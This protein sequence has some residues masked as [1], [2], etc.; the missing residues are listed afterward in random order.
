MTNWDKIWKDKKYPMWVSNGGLAGYWDKIAAERFHRLSKNKKSSEKQVEELNLK[1][2]DIVLDIGCGTGRLTLP[3]A[4]R[5]K[6]VYGIDISKEMLEIV[7]RES[8]KEGLKNVKLINADFETFDISNIKKVDVSISYNSLG[9]Y[10][11][12][13][14]LKR[15]DDV[16]K[17]EV[18]IFTFASKGEWLDEHLAE[19]IYGK[20]IKN[21]PTS[22][23]IICNL[24]KERGIIAD[25]EIRHTV[26]KSKYNSVDEAI[27]K[28]ME[29]YKF[30]S[31]LKGEVKNFVRNNYRYDGA[32]YIISQKRDIAKIH[33]RVRNG[34]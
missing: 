2:T 7:K 17:R 29:F 27:E 15:I 14:V 4:K 5:V 25:L 3:I 18:F 12:K 30:E 13:R 1:Q 31:N 21:V 10:D 16:T 33:W 9:V 28:L 34:R 20:Q 6:A 32:K 26:W 23:E 24:L 22:T 19:V 8:K 11:I